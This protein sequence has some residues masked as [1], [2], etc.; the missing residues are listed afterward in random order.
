ME[1][2]DDIEQGNNLATNISFDDRNDSKSTSAFPQ[3]QDEVITR[4][5][6]NIHT[7][8]SMMKSQE[9]LGTTCQGSAL[10]SIDE[11]PMDALAERRSLH[12]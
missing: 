7:P 1:K 6:D 3:S 9:H 2:L 10:Q 12:A 8:C 4:S 5:S 11:E